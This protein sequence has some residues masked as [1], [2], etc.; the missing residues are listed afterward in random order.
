MGFSAG[1]TSSGTVTNYSI[2]STIDTFAGDNYNYT[3]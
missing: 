2:A 1:S 3:G